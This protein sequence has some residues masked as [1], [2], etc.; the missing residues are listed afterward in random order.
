MGLWV[1]ALIPYLIFSLR[2]DTLNRNAFYLLVGLSA[3]FSFWHVVLPR[4]AAYDFGFLIIAAAPFITR[5]FSRIYVSPD[6]HVKLDVHILGNLMWIRLGLVALLVLREWEPGP[7]GLWPT[8]AEWRS[9]A[10]YYA[11]V[12]LPL[13]AV[14]L[15]T[16]DARWAPLP[17]EWWRVASVGL[18]TFF[19]FLWVTAVGEELFFRGVVTR[20]L[21]D[22]WPK[23]PAVFMSALLFGC[24][25]FWF[26]G[27]PDWRSA[28]VAVLLGV[29]CG[30]AYAQTGSVRVP[31]VAHALVVTT[32]K[33]FFK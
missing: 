14:A 10:L 1:S 32:W 26:R 33:V 13:V 30:W 3:I 6:R 8:L 29:F 19:G 9:G 22:H 2:A 21:L 15:A 11:A 18:A 5:V 20:A 25:H 28:V 23:V 7:F 12:L 16:K 31:M 17:G 4:R 27:F 24:A